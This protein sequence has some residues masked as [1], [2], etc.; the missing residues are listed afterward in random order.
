MTE[1]MNGFEYMLNVV[2]ELSI[3][4]LEFMGVATILVGAVRAVY[5]LFRRHPGVRLKL[6]ESMALALEF[7]LGGEILRTVQVR[8]WSE[9]AIV[10]AI[11]LLRGVL[12]LLI[13]HEIRVE[14]ERDERLKH[15]SEQ[16]HMSYGEG[17]GAQHGCVESHCVFPTPDMERTAE[18]YSRCL[19]FRAERYLNAAQPHICLYREGIEIILIDSHGAPVRTNRDLYGSGCDGY[20][21]TD[22]QTA[23]EREFMAKGARIP[24]P[25]ENDNGDYE[26]VVEDVDGRYL[27]FGR[28]DR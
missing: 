13:H 11:I 19:G 4:I 1:F 5:E 7:K 20:F 8:D 22:A 2:I 25:L 16:E 23:L 18:W 14:E 15:A 17:T 9:I 12:N 27:C 6:A 21:I 28:K 24:K 3:H 10:G 26:F